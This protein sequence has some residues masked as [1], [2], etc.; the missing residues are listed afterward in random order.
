MLHLPAHATT[1]VAP[2]EIVADL[3]ALANAPTAVAQRG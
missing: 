2:N 3:T 1:E